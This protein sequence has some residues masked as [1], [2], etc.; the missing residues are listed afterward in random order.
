M[1]V[2]RPYI[3][4]HMMMTVDGR[5]DC[6]MTEKIKGGDEYYE[7]LEELDL[8]S[9][10]SGRNTAQIEIA[11]KGLFEVHNPETLG[12]ES[13]SKKVDSYG[14]DIV[15]D[16]KGKLLWPK[17]D[18]SDKPTLIIT[19]EGITKEYLEYLDKQGISWIA[20]GKDRIDLH[21]AM[22]ILKNEFGV[23]R[24]GIVGGGHINAGFL[25]EG[26]LDEVSI[27]LGPGI[28]GRGGMT[29]TFDGLPMDREPFD[30]TL[31]DFKSYADG[32]IWIRY[33]VDK[34]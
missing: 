12:N 34:R 31:K 11:K 27:V 7:T 13:F 24:L 15:V 33:L 10:L 19:S 8:P 6:A 9:T 18:G 30:L 28:D 5:I 17:Y 1:E 26:L 3:V 14:Y 21:R 2:R 20:T 25:D 4:C 32:T 22:D 16:T 29:T 23:E